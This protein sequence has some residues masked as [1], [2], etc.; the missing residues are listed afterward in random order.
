M[1]RAKELGR[2]RL[3]VFDHAMRRRAGE[4]LRIDRD[5]RMAI[6]R[7]EFEVHYQPEIDLA[8]GAVV[9]VEALL[10]WNHPDLGLLLPEDFLDVAEDTGIIVSIG[11]W[12]LEQALARATTWSGIG[13]GGADLTLSVNLS[14]RQVGS[15][16]LVPLVASELD[17]FGWPAERLVV[18]LDESMLM[19]DREVTLDALTEL[20][21][22]GV[23]IAIDDFGTGYSSLS[24]LHRFPI[25]VV[26]ID[27]SFVVTL[28]EDGTGSP[29]VTAIVQMAHDLGIVAAA[30]GVEHED[31]LL[32]LRELGCDRAQGFH[33]CGAL[34][35]AE[36][37]E[38][39]REGRRW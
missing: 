4:R 29:V 36:L 37:D 7:E 13:P 26:K 24:Y 18:E 14:G 23:R 19:D 12:V 11:T 10:R 6:E 9:S 16:A 3:E 28:R 25:D 2:G 5:L 34:P 15:P 17:R 27:P 21:R 33:F 32:A 39:L 35:A 30:E 22:L 8:T 1:F 31:Q 20:Q 38:L